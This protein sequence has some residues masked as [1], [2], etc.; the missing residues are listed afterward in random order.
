MELEPFLQYF[1]QGCKFQFTRDFILIDDLDGRVI[2]K[3]TFHR[4]SDIPFVIEIVEK[5]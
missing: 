4:F 2:Y 3:M 5:Y 1:F